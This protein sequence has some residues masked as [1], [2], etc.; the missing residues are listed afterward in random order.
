MIIK[1]A[2]LNLVIIE[3]M[4]IKEVQNL[5][6]ASSLLKNNNLV[7]KSES[8]TNAIDTP[9]KWCLHKQIAISLL[10]SIRALVHWAHDQ[11]VE[12]N[13]HLSLIKYMTLSRNGQL[14]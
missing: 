8:V 2:L 5:M 13:R 6:G 10:G 9:A 1:V 3:N 4:M 14:A 7:Y 11:R 12:R